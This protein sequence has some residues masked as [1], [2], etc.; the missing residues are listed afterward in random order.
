MTEPPRRPAG[1]WTP[2]ELGVH[3]VIGGGPMRAA[4]QVSLEDAEYAA[5]LLRALGAAHADDAI[6]VLLAR[7]PAGQAQL[8]FP[9]DLGR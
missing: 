9:E 5:R 2:A 1:R 6:E 4:P 7:D 8:M 3:P